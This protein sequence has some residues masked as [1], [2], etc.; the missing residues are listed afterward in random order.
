ML[1][2]IDRKMGAKGL[3]KGGTCGALL[4]DLSK[5]FDCLVHDLLIAN[6]LRLIY[7]YLVGRKQR[8]KIDKEYSTWQEILFGVPQDSILDPLFFNIHM[9]HL[10]FIAESI[11]IAS[12]ADD[13][14]P[15]VYLEDMDLI[16]EKLE[17]KANDIFQCF[18]ENAMK[19]NTDK[20]HLL[21]T[22]NEE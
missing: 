13:T 15:Y 19:A 6:S 4:T 12:Y 14:T 17:V 8:V 10:F 16:I 7:I 18:N 3:D 20:C 2:G 9:S 22:T 5:A 11:D 1:T 21:I